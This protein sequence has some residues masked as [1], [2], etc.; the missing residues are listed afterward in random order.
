[1]WA[2]KKTTQHKGWKLAREPLR[3]PPL[4]A[5]EQKQMTEE[6]L[7]YQPILGSDFY[8]ISCVGAGSSPVSLEK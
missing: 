7:T 5:A 6:F 4:S 8:G 1:M 3:C 2:K